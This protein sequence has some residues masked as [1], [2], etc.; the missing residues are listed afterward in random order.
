MIQQL[1]WLSWFNINEELFDLKVRVDLQYADGVIY[2]YTAHVFPQ[3]AQN[4]KLIIPT[5]ILQIGALDENDNQEI[6][7]YSVYLSSEGNTISNVMHYAIDQRYLPYTRYF[8][9]KNSFG[10]FDTFYTHGKKSTSYGIEK[11]SAKFINETTFK[12]IEF[13]ITLQSK[14]VINTGYKSKAE[15]S[16]LRDFFLSVDKF[17]LIDQLW[18]SV[19]VATNTIEEFEDGKGLFALQFEVIYQEMDNLQIQIY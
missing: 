17:M 2:T 1:S 11:S 4:E 7:S 18:T 6:V 8:L 5:G 9:F 3:V 12:E 14:E 13:D 15:I 10:S 16:A 19:N